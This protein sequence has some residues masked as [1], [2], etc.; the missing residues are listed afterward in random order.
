MTDLAVTDVAEAQRFEARTPDGELLGIAAYERRG[1]DV[2]L[3]HT[4]V[5]PAAEGHGV[6]STLVREVLD[7]LRASGDRVVPQCPFV[8]AFVDAH[9]EYGDLM[10]DRGR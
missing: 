7:R 6:G 2:V 8:R 3:T 4:V 10:A 1:D 5:E 9:P